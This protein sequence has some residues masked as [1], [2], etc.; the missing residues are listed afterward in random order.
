MGKSFNEN[1]RVKEEFQSKIQNFRADLQ[2][3]FAE[4]TNSKIKFPTGSII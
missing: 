3:F 4:V 1:S 2:K